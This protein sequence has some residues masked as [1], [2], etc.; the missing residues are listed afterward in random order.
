MLHLFADKWFSKC[1]V[2]C[3][4]GNRLI[5][6]IISRGHVKSP[7]TIY[8]ITQYWVGLVF[9]TALVLHLLSRANPNSYLLLWKTGNLPIFV[10]QS[11]LYPRDTLQA[12]WLLFKHLWC[13]GYT[14]TDASCPTLYHMPGCHPYANT[15]SSCCLMSASC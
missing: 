2:W 7:G 9:P 4:R 10:G 11:D 5:W 13:Y 6:S 12:P 15:W 3:K 8:S 1:L 14:Y